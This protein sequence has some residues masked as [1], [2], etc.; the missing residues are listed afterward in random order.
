M[1]QT[2]STESI[3][4]FHTRQTQ[5]RELSSDHFVNILQDLPRCSKDVGPKL[6]PL[7]AT[8]FQNLH[9]LEKDAERNSKQLPG[10]GALRFCLPGGKTCP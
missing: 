4:H 3:N 1:V 8:N 7:T 9:F 10:S 5:F 6:S 2:Y